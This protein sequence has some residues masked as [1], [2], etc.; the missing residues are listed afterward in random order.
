MIPRII[1]YIWFGNQAKKPAERIARWEAALPDWEFREWTEADLDINKYPYVKIAYDMKRYGIC[2]DPFRP[3]ILYT[4]GGVWLDTDVEVHKDL[5]V[6]LDCDLLVGCHHRIGVSLGVL[7]TSP[8]NPVMKKSMEWYDNRW[9]KSTIKL[10][11]VSPASFA[12]LHGSQNAPEPIFLSLLRQMYNISPPKATKDITTIDGVIRF[13]AP[14]ILTTKLKSHPETNYTE[15]LYEG[16][17]CKD[18]RAGL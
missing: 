10:G 6:F 3:Y 12:A 5:S 1:H 17:W 8:G 16:S 7:G 9:M 18:V 11:D 15:H 4:H 14:H 13:E 2:I